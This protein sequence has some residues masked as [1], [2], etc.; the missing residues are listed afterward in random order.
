[1]MK[2]ARR[3]G[4]SL[5]L[6]CSAMSLE[7]IQAQFAP[8]G[9]GLPPRLIPASANGQM[10]GFVP[11]APP[12]MAAMGPAT[13]E[14]AVPGMR[15][16]GAD[17]IMTHRVPDR[18]AWAPGPLEEFLTAATRQMR[19]RLDYML[20]HFDEPGRVR[21]GAPVSGVVD[22][23]Q[24]FEV[25]DRLTGVSRGNA[26]VP[27]LQS[28]TLMDVNGIRG[29]FEIPYKGGVFEASAWATQQT[30]DGQFMAIAPGGTQAA[31][32]LFVNGI[33]VS[34]NT[35]VYDVSFE[36][37]LTSELYGGDLTLIID[38]PT[39][40][41]GLKFRPMLGFRYLNFQE[42]LRQKGVDTNGGTEPTRS[43]VIDSRT[44]NNVYGPQFGLRVELTHPKFTLGVQP[45]ITAGLND[46]TAS[47]RAERLFTVNDPKLL[48]KETH[49]DWSPVFDLKV[50][51]QAHISESLSLHVGYD[52]MWAHR[53]TRPYNNIY[54]DEIVTGGTRTANVVLQEDLE[55]FM[56]DGLTVGGVI[57]F[58]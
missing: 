54:Y 47:V 2:T 44:S 11:G 12:S 38:D 51:L 56:V 21:L 58:K 14:N 57:R 7:P 18:D 19:F 33:P 27:D 5:V 31:T 50:Y 43:V 28:A 23:T 52:L 10:A 6:V 3:F 9:A 34:D 55:D 48:T 1:M 13:A 15:Y 29:T 20:W 32:S 36:T 49:T 8:P 35:I 4:F 22:T 25:F 30:G 16:V 17:G 46:Y 26:F 42:Q 40:G 53:V 41:H 37:D 39:P 24:P 45:S